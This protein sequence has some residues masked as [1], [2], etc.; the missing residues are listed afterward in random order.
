MPLLGVRSLDSL[1]RSDSMSSLD[2]STDSGHLDDSLCSSGSEDALEEA[3]VYLNIDI[4][5]GRIS[6]VESR[7][8]LILEP[9]DDSKDLICIRLSTNHHSFSLKRSVTIRTFNSFYYLQETL[10]LLHPYISVPSLPPKPL[11]MFSSQQQKLQKLAKFL[12]SVLSELQYHSN[13][14]LHLF[15]QTTLSLERIQLNLD[16]VRDD[17][18]PKN[19]LEDRR[20]NSK[21][22]FNMIFGE[23]LNS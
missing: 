22:G 15:L 14:A 7:T 5:D 10:K 18:V 13:K 1:G 2:V 12:S 11:L 4:E 20:S 16:G 21:N 9:V 23:S 17:D 6:P 8:I 3:G 19:P